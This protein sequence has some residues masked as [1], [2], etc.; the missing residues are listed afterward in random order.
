MAMAIHP[1]P[2]VDVDPERVE[3]ERRGFDEP[4]LELER[5]MREAH[6]QDL[7]EVDAGEEPDEHEIQPADH[8]AP[9]ETEL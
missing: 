5:A 2:R 1:R 3:Q 6:V 7:G 4:S 9:A 8:E